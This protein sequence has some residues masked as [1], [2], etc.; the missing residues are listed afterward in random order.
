MNVVGRPQVTI[1]KIASKNPLEFKIRYALFPDISLPDYKKIAKTIFDRKDPTDVTEKEV[2]EAV[3]RI[4]KMIASATAGRRS[5]E[6][7]KKTRPFPHLP[8]RT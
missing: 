8:T 3:E 7:V 2:D 5:R 6:R 1:T 4:Q